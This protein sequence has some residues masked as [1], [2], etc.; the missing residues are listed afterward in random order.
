MNRTSQGQEFLMKESAST[1]SIS[2]IK[3]VAAIEP[4]GGLDS[5]GRKQLRPESDFERGVKVLKKLNGESETERVVL[6]TISVLKG[7]WRFVRRKYWRLQ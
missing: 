2:A 7:R 6:E 1:L 4:P 5:G 3:L